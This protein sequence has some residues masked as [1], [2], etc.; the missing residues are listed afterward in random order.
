MNRHENA[1]DKTRE[2][3]FHFARGNFEDS[4]HYFSEAIKKDPK[5]HMAYLSRGAAYVKMERIDD[6]QR[7]F[8]KA[9]KLMPQDAKA[10]HFL[11]LA[12]LQKGDRES[13][14]REFDQAI[15]LNPGYGVAYFSRGTTRSEMGDEDGGG[16]DM[17][18]AARIG[19]ANLQNFADNHNIWRT[20]YDKVLAELNG[21]REPDIA[22]KPDLTAWGGD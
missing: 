12:Y 22:M 9:V 18:T 20:K 10:H 8:E 21:E 2:G 3:A 17:K 1:K 19:E 15:E 14:R 11:G 5:A 16:E 7:D 4:I 6:A 13:A